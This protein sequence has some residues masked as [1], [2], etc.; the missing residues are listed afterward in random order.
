[1]NPDPLQPF[2]QPLVTATGIL[3][4]FTLNIAANWVAKAFASD[5]VS[6]V[7]LGICICC[8]IPIYS[9]V[10]YRVLNNNYPREKAA[11]Y[12]R[13]TLIIF[14]TAISIAF[15]SIVVI[16]IESMLIHRKAVE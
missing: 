3:L 8:Q 10:L 1:M 2:R 6:E 9:I 11:S 12:Y 13:T 4:G 14:I 15:L 5:R 16:M 7:I